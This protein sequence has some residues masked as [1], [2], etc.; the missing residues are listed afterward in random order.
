M[1]RRQQAYVDAVDLGLDGLGAP[2]FGPCTECQSCEDYLPTVGGEMLDKGEFSWLAC[3]ICGCRLGGDR[4]VWH[5]VDEDGELMHESDGCG[6]CLVYLSN[7]DLPPDEYLEWTGQ[8]ESE[9]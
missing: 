6:D 8:P 5:W 1:S 2:S 9:E 3:G 7:G 4:Y